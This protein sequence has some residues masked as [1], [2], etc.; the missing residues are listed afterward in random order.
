MTPKALANYRKPARALFIIGV[1]IAALFLFVDQREQIAMAFARLDPVVLPWAFLA[2]LGFAASSFVS[3]RVLV[4]T[5]PGHEKTAMR[6]FFLSQ[7]GKYL[8]G[9]I[10]QFVAVAD[11]GQDAGISSR[12][13]VSSSLVA[14]GGATLAGLILTVIFLPAVLVDALPQSDGTIWLVGLSTIVLGALMLKSRLPSFGLSRGSVVLP[15]MSRLTASVAASLLTFV[16]SGLH[17]FALSAG[18]NLG[19]AGSAALA[20]DT[21]TAVMTILELSAVFAAAWVVGLLVIIAPAGIGA[22]EGTMVTLLLAHMP[23]SEALVIALLARLL[24]TIADFALGGAALLIRAE[25]NDLAHA[26]RQPRG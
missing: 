11:Y 4:T 13:A 20:S 17:L 25:P 16:M 1:A 2:A 22:R 24:M 18:L 19:L 15:Q 14:L 12:T 26:Q 8:P 7:M 5:E 21:Y 10:W 9:G 6:V 3:W 23:L